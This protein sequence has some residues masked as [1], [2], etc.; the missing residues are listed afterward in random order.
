MCD[1]CVSERKRLG[2]GLSQEMNTLF[3]F[4][5]FFLRDNFNRKMYEEFKQYAVEDAKENYRWAD[6]H[7]GGAAPRRCTDVGKNLQGLKQLQRQS[8]SSKCEHLPN[9]H[10][11]LWTCPCQ[12]QSTWIQGVWAELF[13]TLVSCRFRLCVSK[14][15]TGLSSSA[16]NFHYRYE[17]IPADK[18][19]DMQL[20]KLGWREGGGEGCRWLNLISCVW[21]TW[22][23]GC[24]LGFA[25]FSSPA[26][27][28]W[29]V[30]SDTTATV[31]R[32]DSG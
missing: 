31:W 11:C 29:S 13:L 15:G 3:R 16:A 14:Q 21:C 24:W 19:V 4:W 30:S 17:N 28:D 5:S 23:S 10:S 8:C 32:E 2:V 7:D 26:G 6:H 18:T 12:S 1:W 22:V 9:P 25:L 20:Q 27:M